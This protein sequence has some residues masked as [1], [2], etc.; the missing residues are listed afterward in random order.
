MSNLPTDW[1]R[2]IGAVAIGRNEG[3][4]LRLC[5]ESLAGRVPH[6]VYV[7]SGSTDDSVALAER[8][9]AM[10]VA[11]DMSVPFT[12]ARARNAG[13]E[14]LLQLAPDIEFVQF[15]DGDCQVTATWLPAAVAAL[16]ARP[17]A[18][19]VCGRRRERYPDATLYN[20]LTQMTDW[21][22]PPG[23]VASCG[24]DALMRVGALRDVGGFDPT[25]IAGEEPELCLRLRRRGGRIWQLDEDMTWHDAALTR[26]GQWW[27]RAVRAGH[28]HA[29]GA[30]R[31]GRGPERFWVRQT[32]SA[33]TWGALLWIAPLLLAWATGGWSL[34]ILLAYPLQ[35]WRLTLQE[36][37]KGRSWGDAEAYGVFI[38]IAKV[39]Q[40]WGASKFAGNLLFGRRTRL[41]EYK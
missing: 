31:H 41:I 26:F 11:L 14:R 35:A 28:G 27:K 8:L 3:E 4:R 12:A 40:A 22:H 39:A 29:E 30:Y 16:D 17:D 32:A 1:E 25:L 9:G 7:D 2:R 33:L 10:V 6:V 19:V 23:E 15:V 37:A 20:R 21:D 18:V 13:L 34:L 5:L 24:G 38:M 36:R